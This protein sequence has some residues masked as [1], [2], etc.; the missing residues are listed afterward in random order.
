VTKPITWRLRAA[1]TLPI[2]SDELAIRQVFRFVVYGLATVVVVAVVGLAALSVR[3]AAGPLSLALL[4]PTLEIVINHYLAPER[5][6][7]SQAYA[8]WRGWNDGLSLRIDGVALHAAGRNAPIAVVPRLDLLFSA[9]ALR[10][11]VF[12]P[13]TVEVGGLRLDL[14]GSAEGVLSRRDASGEDEPAVDALIARALD[15]LVAPPDAARP[16]SYLERIVIRDGE[17]M[18]TDAAS[19]R[20]VRARLT[21]VAAD[22][23]GDGLELN[24]DVRITGAYGDVP[25]RLVGDVALPQGG[26]AAHLAFSGVALDRFA[27]ID[28]ALAPLAAVALPLSGEITLAAERP[29]VIDRVTFDV[30][31]EGGELRLTPDL[32][33]RLGDAAWTQTVAIARVAARGTI[34]LA[35]G[36][37]AVDAFSLSFAPKSEIAVPPLDH[38]FPVRSLSARGR[39]AGDRLDVEEAVV[40][41]GEPTLRATATV[42]GLSERLAAEARVRIDRLPMDGIGRYWPKAVAPGGLEWCEQHLSRGTVTMDADVALAD[43]GDGLDLTRFV[44]T[45]TGEGARVDYLPDLPPVENARAQGRLTLRDLSLTILGGNA[46]ALVVR[47]GTV[48]LNQFDKPTQ[49][50]AIDL[51][52]AGPLAAAID[53]LGRPPLAF[54]QGIALDARGISGQVA[55]RLQLAFPLLQDLP[56][57][58]LRMLVTARIDDAAVTPGL[59]GVTVHDGDFRLRVTGQ[60][61]RLAGTVELAGVRGSLIWEEEFDARE[62]VPTLVSFRASR[63][64]VRRLAEPVDAVDIGRFVKSGAIDAS[65]EFRRRRQLPYELWAKLDLTRADV[66]VPQ[67]GWQKPVGVRSIAEATVHLDDGGV[68]A[69]PEVSAYG[70]GLVLKGSAR[71]S[72]QGEIERIDIERLISGRTDV[73]ATLAHRVGAGWDIEVGGLSLDL[74]PLRAALARGDDLGV[75]KAGRTPPAAAPSPPLS[76]SVNAEIESVW[77]GEDRSLANVAMTAVREGEALVLLQLD[78]TLR[79]GGTVL[80]TLTPGDPGRRTLRADASDAGALL[81]ALDLYDQVRGGTL[82]LTGEFDDTKRGNPLSGIVRVRDFNVVE[83]PILAQ[84]L[85]VLALSG[86]VDTLQ[87]T[88]IR[89]STFILPFVWAEGKLTI[90]EARTFGLSLGMTASG[91]LDTTTDRIDLSGTLIPFYFIN[92]ALGQLPLIGPLFTGGE[93]G[94]GLFAA[95]YTIRGPVEEPEVSV[96]PLSTLLPSF[97]RDVLLWL[98]ELIFPSSVAVEP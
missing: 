53:V 21:E 10:E 44:A 96:N 9:E 30:T 28:E 56:T 88:G 80:V 48:V 19:G 59:F 35:A 97:L 11:R 78:A 12:V 55:T 5:V 20:T 54:T 25:L 94:G 86:I 62:K 91:E 64:P 70:G 17:L 63:V 31:S 39:F 67:L 98:Q 41:L 6:Q 84:L 15:E 74:A 69:I 26:I 65:V 73:H 22:R 38:R 77:F 34:A 82:R 87:G 18:F 27:V 36:E 89:F 49:A 16:L 50:I 14:V 29:T 33:A 81:R 37:I 93:K 72:R 76:M 24:A 42:Q 51:D 40:D 45:L 85:S 58:Q 1:P 43:P 90:S 13:A 71:F 47:G 46:G 32:A 92:S 23:S 79:E 52:I 57:E 8:T 95:T 83:A 4:L 60:E 3:L 2:T 66:T 68:R 61:L 7:I 75:E